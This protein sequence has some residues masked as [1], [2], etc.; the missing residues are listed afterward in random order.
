MNAPKPLASLSSTLLARKGTAR[1]AMRPQGFGVFGAPP[2]SGPAQ[3]DLGWND[4]G[5]G[6]AAV[7]PVPPV[8][9]EREALQEEFAAQPAPAEPDPA[10]SMDEAKPVEPAKPAISVATATRIGRETRAKHK[11]QAKSAFTLRLDADRHLKLRLASALQHRSAQ[12]I[13]TEALDAFLETLPEV[14]A[15][16]SQLPT[17]AAR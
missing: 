7:A 13:V 14:D 3:D 4:M 2:A 15:L 5:D 6:E 12:L 9:I 17:R 1:P 16:L 8:L 10:P 11:G